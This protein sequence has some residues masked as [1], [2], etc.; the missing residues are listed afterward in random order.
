VTLLP[1]TRDHLNLAQKVI[2]KPTVNPI[3]RPYL[4][5]KDILPVGKITG[6]EKIK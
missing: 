6:I 4:N 1:A 2:L 5:T 3:E